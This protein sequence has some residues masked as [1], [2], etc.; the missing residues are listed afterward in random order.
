MLEEKS[1]FLFYLFYRKGF[2]RFLVYW[3]EDA[4]LFLIET[5]L[6]S[7]YYSNAVFIPYWC[8]ELLGH[9]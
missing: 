8:H 9:V 4:K 3:R 6:I 1:A 5:P 7:I 2:L